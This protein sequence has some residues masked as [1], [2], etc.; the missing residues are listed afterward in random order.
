MG[1]AAM[2]VISLWARAPM[3]VLN[4]SVTTKIAEN[5]YLMRFKDSSSPFLAVLHTPTYTPACQM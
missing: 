4:T 1:P 5:K 2:R 3:Q